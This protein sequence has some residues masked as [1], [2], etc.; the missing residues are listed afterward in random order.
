ME[1]HYCDVCGGKTSGV[2]TLSYGTEYAPI[3][4]CAHCDDA[5]E[6]AEIGMDIIDWFN[7][8]IDGK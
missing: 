5:N 1:I 2:I 8:L 6:H 7:K 3:S 4:L